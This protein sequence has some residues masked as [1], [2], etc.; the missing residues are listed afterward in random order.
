MKYIIYDKLFDTAKAEL[1]AEDHSER[2]PVYFYKTK[3]GEF[4]RVFEGISAHL[5]SKGLLKRMLRQL[6][7]VEAYINIFGPLKEC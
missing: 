7:K 4:V 5:I 3:S 2:V 1:I 6:N